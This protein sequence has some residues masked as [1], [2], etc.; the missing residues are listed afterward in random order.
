[1]SHPVPESAH[2]TSRSGGGAAPTYT[3][4]WAES[5]Q[6]V[7]AAQHLRFQVFNLELQEGLERSFE[8]GLD[9][10]RFDAVCDHLLVEEGSTGEIIGTYR[11]Q[12]GSGAGAGLG[13]YG[14]QE[15]DFA[16]YEPLRGEL[17][18]LG[19]ACIRAD[20]RS[21]SVLNLLWKGI[22]GY[23]RRHGARYLVGCSSL[24][25]QDPAI[26]LSAF[27]SLEP[28]LAPSNLRT[29]PLA[30]FRCPPGIAEEPPARIP[31]LLR[32]YLALG[33]WIC[34]PPALDREF[35]TIDFLTLLDL[36]SL[37]LRALRLLAEGPS[38]SR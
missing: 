4:R 11:M 7:H 23:A 5:L 31:K 1:M 32:A 37:P 3:L 35:G 13:Y 10:D 9:S 14:A 36:E 6:D 24:N 19:R 17:I 22:A 28:H 29:F 34:G 18:E 15:F 38:R 16:P 2:A 12:T 30:G 8:T 26:A 25:S 27:Q 20:H 33:A 21:F